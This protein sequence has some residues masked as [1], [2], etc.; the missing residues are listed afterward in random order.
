MY[1]LAIVSFFVIVGL[2]VIV[3]VVRNVSSPKPQTKGVTTPLSPT[4]TI[5]PTTV[6]NEFPDV[7]VSSWGKIPA[8][9]SAPL[10]IR[11][12]VYALKQNYSRQ[13]FANLAQHFVSIVGGDVQD[14][15]VTARVVST[16]GDPAVFYM[17]KPSGSFY[18][19]AKKGVE[20]PIGSNESDRVTAFMKSLWNDDTLVVTGSH[21]SGSLSGI[22]LY[23][24]HRD[25]D[26]VGLP[27]LNVFGILQSSDDEIGTMSL[28][29]SSGINTGVDVVNTATVGVSEGRIVYIASS[30]R[31]VTPQGTGPKPIVSY[32]D[33]MKTLQNGGYRFLYVNAMS[34]ETSIMLTNATV[35]EAFIAYLEDIPDRSQGQLTPD[36]VF[37]GI[38]ETKAG[39]KVA[40]VAAVA[41][42]SPA[43]GGST[44]IAK[45]TRSQQQGTLAFVNPTIAPRTEGARPSQQATPAAALKQPTCA[46]PSM[47]DL[48]SIKEDAGGSRFGVYNSVWYVVTG[49]G[50]AVSQIPPVTNVTVK[51]VMSTIDTFSSAILGCPIKI[52]L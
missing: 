50:W 15:G 51:D 14:N 38:A 8:A 11:S 26:K 46:A 2:A 9:P 41:A 17:Y 25:W 13:E 22:K 19:R 43:N 44:A 29:D 49:G 48:K 24:V 3:A 12:T 39:T 42:V 47:K 27:V 5:D 32:D 52:A 35:S 7:T 10:P 40:F 31:P 34:D 18:F 6:K 36:V 20:L 28:L 33:A 23:E 21:E 16:K 1:R 4:K 37:R 30:I 45:R